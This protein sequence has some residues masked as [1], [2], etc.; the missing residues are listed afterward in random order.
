MDGVS[1]REP[2]RR[3]RASRAV[4]KNAASTPETAAG[5]IVPASTGRRV[6]RLVLVAAVAVAAFGAVASVLWLRST[7]SHV[8]PRRVVLISIDTLRADHLGCYGYEH[9]RTPNI[10]ALAREGTLFE[11]A[12]SATPLT[13]PAHSSIMTGRTPLHHG[14]I[15]NFGFRLPPSETTLA[16]RLEQAGMATGGFVGSFVLDSRWGISQGFQTYFDHFDSP[17]ESGTALSSHQ[18]TADQVLEPALRWMEQQ[19]DRPFFAFVHFFDPHTPYAPPERIRASFPDTDVGRYDGEI[20]FVDEQVGRLFAFLEE[21][22]L[23]EDA[24]IVLMGDHGE[25]LG[26]H[27]EST[28]G[29]F[30]YDATMHVPLIMRGPGVAPH[31]RIPGQVRSIDVMPTVLALLG[32]TP[33]SDVDGVSLEALLEG[34]ARDLNLTAYVESHYARLHFGWAPLRGLRIARF[35]FIDAP[36]AELYNLKTDPGETRN[37][38]SERAGAVSELAAELERL[39]GGESPRLALTPADP[40]TEAKLRSLGYLTSTARSVPVTQE[41]SLP[42]PKDEIDTFNR[43]TEATVA[44]LTGDFDKASSL[45][46][47]VV[48]DDPDVMI[49]YMMLG[50]IRLRQK[51]YRAA[52]SIFRNALERNDESVEGTYGLALAYK[53]EGKLDE[54]AAGFQKVLG[55][56]QNQVRAVYQL[57]EVRLAQGRPGEAERLLEERLAVEADSSL[58]LVLAQAFLTQGRKD[59]AAT[60]LHDAE[61]DDPANPLVQLNLGNLLLEDGK[62]DEALATYRRAESLDEKDAQIA[63]ALG[64]ALARHGEEAASLEAFRKATELDPNFAPARNNLG[65]ALARGGSYPEAEKAFRRA[66]ELDPDYAEAYNNLAFL[67]LQTGSARRAIPLLRRALALEPG[68]AQAR[69]NLEEAIRRGSGPS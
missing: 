17:S 66:I 8:H 69:R 58:R 32:L 45:L 63:N 21:K 60:V 52:E 62:V 30:I 13:L 35:K 67:Y 54:A 40:A 44:N 36:K 31:Q 24:L 15:D 27:G 10:D 68:Y 5:A 7:S 51:D 59:D 26:D 42:D 20:A 6:S 46:G 38:A 64:N 25:S 12:A 23:Y 53:G 33:S 55:L 47:A 34:R 11:N 43:V 61:R 65:I 3:K 1:K 49:A 9:A 41:S 14:I 16:E 4:R 48:K 28:H 19:G 56:D 18:R 37:L 2:G 50:N 39:R 22:H 57:A 29:L